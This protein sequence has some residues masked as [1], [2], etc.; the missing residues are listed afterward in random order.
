LCALKK[1]V[2]FYFK[3]GLTASFLV[4]DNISE[5]SVCKFQTEMM[6]NNRIPGLL[7][8]NFSTAGG[9]PEFYYDI[10]SK[11]ALKD[12]LKRNGGAEGF[13]AVLISI[14]SALLSSKGYLLSAGN[15]LFDEELIF[16]N[17]S[18]LD[19]Y[20][21]YLPVRNE[22]DGIQEFREFVTGLVLKSPDAAENMPESFLQNILSYLKGE[23]FSIQEF[24]R[25]L[26]DVSGH[27]VREELENKANIT[28]K[29]TYCD[30]QNLTV[31][32]T[33]SCGR[34]LKAV[35]SQV[36]LAVILVFAALK[37][38]LMSAGNTSVYAG[39][40]IILA[41]LDI[42]LLKYI[43]TGK[44]EASTVASDQS[45]AKP[46]KS[47]K[48][49]KYKE[50][51]DNENEKDYFREENCRETAVLG[52]ASGGYPYLKIIKDGHVEEITIDKPEFIIGRL[53]DRVD[54]CVESSAVGKVHAAIT[55][56][57][58]E[59]FIKD[60]NSKNGTFLNNTRLESNREYSI[61]NNDRITFANRDYLFTV[62]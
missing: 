1:A 7:C 45:D 60:I 36:L 8:F 4:F 3:S 47:I 37:T 38:N 6:L 31:F 16:V 20:L 34:I 29:G 24:I 18:T 21:V 30:S 35:C 13:A 44:R 54:Y 43:L 14:C 32:K 42:L 62:P 22:G 2:S 10:T 55:S 41:A 52:C 28:E 56:R 40:G 26:S 12:F 53:K 23:T 9:K 15:F 57:G 50:Y 61:K 39:A 33:K 27:E 48:T 59:Y 46:Y 11:L 58:N 17:P 25:L 5:E 51:L 49:A 19:S